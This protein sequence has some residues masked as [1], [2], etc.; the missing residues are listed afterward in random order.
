MYW[1]RSLNN[2]NN[3]QATLYWGKTQPGYLFNMERLEE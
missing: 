1:S 3:L 2:K